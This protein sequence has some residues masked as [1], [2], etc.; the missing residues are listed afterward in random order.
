MK[1]L[2]AGF[3]ALAT[4]GFMHSAT[5][6]VIV[7]PTSGVIDSGG[8]GY[9][10]LTETYNQAG[11]SSG[12][13]AGVTDFDMYIASNP[14]HTN[15][16]PGYEWFGNSGAG[17]ATVTYNFGSIVTV[18]ALALWNEE[19]TGIGNLDL[20]YSSDGIGFSAL[21]SGLTPTD[22]ALVN[23]SADVFSF[24][25]TSMQYIRFEM[26]SC[27][28]GNVG[29]AYHCAIGE[30]AFRAAETNVPEPGSL[31]LLGLGIVGLTT[32]RRRQAL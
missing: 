3:L 15:T 29:A 11:L 24:A 12:Y 1:S 28:Q 23:Y 30:V 32:M 26:S 2:K 13:T 14:T 10:T 19:S 31:A 7:A 9:G 21:V 27:P 17:D 4:L 20:L 5:A 22:H 16:F 18:D 25:A 8:P 6:G